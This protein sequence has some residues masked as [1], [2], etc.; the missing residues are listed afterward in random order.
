MKSKP[1]IAGA[2][3]GWYA[4]ALLRWW[5]SPQH[6]S[7]KP[8]LNCTGLTH[9]DG[10]SKET[11]QRVKVIGY[12]CARDHE[13]AHSALYER[14]FGSHSTQTS[15]G[16]HKKIR[17]TPSASVRSLQADGTFYREGESRPVLPK[18]FD[19]FIPSIQGDSETTTPL[20]PDVD[21]KM[22]IR[23]FDYMTE[24]WIDFGDEETCEVT[25]L[26]ARFLP[27]VRE[28]RQIAKNKGQDTQVTKLRKI[29]DAFLE[30]GGSNNIFERFR[31]HILFQKCKNCPTFVKSVPESEI[32]FMNAKH[33]VETPA[34]AK[35]GL[36]TGFLRNATEEKPA[37]Y[38]V[39]DETW[40]R[41]KAP[42]LSDTTTSVS[43]IFYK[44]NDPD[45]TEVTSEKIFGGC[46]YYPRSAAL[47]EED[48]SNKV[49]S[50][51]NRVM[52]TKKMM[53]V[54]KRIETGGKMA[55]GSGHQAVNGFPYDNRR[56]KM[57]RSDEVCNADSTRIPNNQVN[58]SRN[59]SGMG[60]PPL[61]K[62]IFCST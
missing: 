40:H 27:V 17:H 12:N 3:Q 36:Q 37:N 50:K 16:K 42:K 58:D 8:E 24:R 52:V 15:V 10:R 46:I 56:S 32:T 33:V 11:C 28:M 57:P 48:E 26:E 35:A 1:H 29:E 45:D 20:P 61:Y 6:A 49:Y 13:T 54:R 21:S 53:V 43:I 62:L 23:I 38:I 14:D 4:R 9:E 7:T 31:S 55:K 41:I 59:D 5:Q 30:E 39:A 2:T 60:P 18:Q 22:L 25:G 44:K 34:D 19:N 51:V 47:S